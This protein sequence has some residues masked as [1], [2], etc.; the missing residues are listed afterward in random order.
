MREEACVGVARRSRLLIAVGRRADW[1]GVHGPPTTAAIRVGG[2]DSQSSS[3][4]SSLSC[5]RGEVTWEGFVPAGGYTT[6]GVGGMLSAA[7]PLAQNG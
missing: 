7:N 2:K 3:T 6:A 5:R 1:T 4:H